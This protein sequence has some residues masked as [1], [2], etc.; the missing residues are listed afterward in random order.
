MVEGAAG[1]TRGRADDVDVRSGAVDGLAA[2]FRGLLIRTSVTGVSGNSMAGCLWIAVWA[3]RQ[4]AAGGLKRSAAASPRRAHLFISWRA[5][6]AAVRSEV[7]NTFAIV[8][9]S[10]VMMPSA[11]L[12]S[13]RAASLA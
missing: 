6:Q 12:S 5:R 2:R 10:S 3:A 13:S 4:A 11:P 9:T 1:N 7:A 8:A